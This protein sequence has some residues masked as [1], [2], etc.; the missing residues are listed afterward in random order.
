M[1]INNSDQNRQYMIYHH[2]HHQYQHK[3]TWHYLAAKSQAR[4]HHQQPQSAGG[5]AISAPYYILGESLSSLLFQYSTVR[6]RFCG[7]SSSSFR[8][9][10]VIKN[11]LV[12]HKE[13]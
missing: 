5:T 8:R 10:I 13:V 1:K 4:H 6:H 7:F 3:S 9:V 11:T 12:V 2:C